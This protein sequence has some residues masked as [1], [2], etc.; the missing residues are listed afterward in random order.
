MNVALLKS[1]KHHLEMQLVQHPL[2]LGNTTAFPLTCELILSLL[3]DKV[4]K[5]GVKIVK[6]FDTA[7][8]AETES[9]KRSSRQCILR[10]SLVERR[11]V[12]VCE[13]IQ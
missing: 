4:E 5:L 12:V 1:T 11:L 3:L 8:R 10:R 13:V 9:S 6:T 2:H 7:N